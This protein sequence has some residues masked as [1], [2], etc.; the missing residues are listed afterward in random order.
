MR[1]MMALMA[2]A[3]LACAGD[4]REESLRKLETL[5]ITVSLRSIGPA[6]AGAGAWAAGA[7]A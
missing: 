4:T 3:A 2:M 5:K 7:G 6:A 1:T